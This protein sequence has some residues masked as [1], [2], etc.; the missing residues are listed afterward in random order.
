MAFALMSK[1]RSKASVSVK[2]MAKRKAGP[3]RRAV[4]SQPGFGNP[5]SLQKVTPLQITP[6]VQAKLKIG[7]PNDK[8]EQ[9]ADRVADRVMRMPEPQV[10]ESANISGSAP[11]TRIQRACSKCG[12]ELSSGP[13]AIQRKCAGCEE[14]DTIQAKEI[15][16]RTPD[17]TPDVQ[18]QINGLRGSGQPLPGSVRA[19]FE[20]RFGYDFS[21]VRVHTDAGAAEA[22]GAINARAFT[23]GR[24]IVFGSGQYVP[25]TT[26]GKSLVAHELTHVAQQSRS[27]EGSALQ[28]KGLASNQRVFMKRKQTGEEI[29]P[30][31]TDGCPKKGHCGPD[32]I[33]QADDCIL[34]TGDVKGQGLLFK[35]KIACDTFLTCEDEKNMEDL[36]DLVAPG[37]LLLVHGFA[38]DEGDSAFNLTLSCA[39]ALKA[40]EILLRKLKPA[41]IL[42]TYMHGATAGNRANRRAVVVEVLDPHPPVTKTLTIVSWIDP[43]PLDFHSKFAIA[44]TP[45]AGGL[46]VIQATEH[47]FKCTANR[48][49][50]ERLPDSEINSFIKTKEYR[51]FQHYSLVLHPHQTFTLGKTVPPKMI[52]GYT[53]PSRC[54]GFPP[55]KYVKGEFSPL[56]LASSKFGGE[57]PNIKALVKIRAGEQEEET[58]IKQ[59]TTGLAGLLVF[60]RKDLPRVPWVWTQSEAEVNPDTQKLVWNVRASAFPTNTI[61]VDGK[62][63]DEIPQKE[64]GFVVSEKFRRATEPR[65]TKEE[66]EA[67]AELPVTM[68]AETVLPGGS[69]N[70]SN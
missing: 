29:V 2:L 41:Q 17:V 21:G 43:T 54:E 52:V 61:Y 30:P 5:D 64:V 55:K 15:S 68:H 18:R 48:R 69:A 25:T 11:P 20:P 45:K 28:T 4:D 35:F 6:A 33:G 44:T 67:Q 7:E 14:E 60:K 46:R 26:V 1:P 13:M 59:A 10:L 9:E 31:V 8:F 51:G 40:R 65:Q 24:D 63:V 58:A 3:V 70:G 53:A 56:S 42:A 50:P 39:R 23:I 37:S 38:S 27:I 36:P 49:P 16:G 32:E 34:L 57:A 22:A 66:E 62:K 19:F 47:I 12:E